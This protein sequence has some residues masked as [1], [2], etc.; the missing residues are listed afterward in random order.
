VDE[1]FARGF[2]KYLAE[3]IAPSKALEK[4]FK[5]FKTWL[6]EIYN[7][8]TGS[9]IDLELN[10]EMRAIYARMLGEKFVSNKTAPT[11]EK[12]AKVTTAEDKE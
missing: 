6:T 1:K 8:I 2:E 11:I 12:E 3:G 7:G 10:D 5:L 9:E 4:V